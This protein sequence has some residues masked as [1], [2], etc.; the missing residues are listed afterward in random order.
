MK[1]FIINGQGGA[2]KT[3]FENMVSTYAWKMDRKKIG[4]CS[5][6]DKIKMIAMNIG[7]TG[8]KEDKDR[9][10]LSDL[11]DLCDKYNDLSYSYIKE[12][13]KEYKEN[14][15]DILFI[16]ARQIEDINRLKKEYNAKT[17]II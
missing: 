6:V 5:M 4:I 13:I 2:G 9:K 7:W 10:F 15:F 17:V 3:S 8:S 11:K 16:D 1:I 12:R 14:N